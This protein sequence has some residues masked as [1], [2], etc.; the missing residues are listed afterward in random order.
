MSY[1]AFEYLAQPQPAAR[2]PPGGRLLN[3]EVALCLSD[4]DETVACGGVTLRSR[5][6]QVNAVPPAGRRPGT[7]RAER[8]LR[9]RVAAL[10]ARLR[11]RLR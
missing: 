4:G 1:L 3:A 7:Q 6:Q 8:R 5:E 2:S 9:R 11:L 10:R